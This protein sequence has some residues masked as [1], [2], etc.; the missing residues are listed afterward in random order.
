ME[1]LAE[2]M[3]AKKEFVFLFIHT[4][5]LSSLHKL[6]LEN[7]KYKDVTHLIKL[8][9]VLNLLNFIH[10]KKSNSQQFQ[11]KF[12]KQEIT[13]WPQLQQ[14]SLKCLQSTSIVAFNQLLQ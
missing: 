6:K 9:F 14:D 13:L 3:T 1:L 10:Y 12:K 4:I 7:K 5:W 2:L 11:I 8:F